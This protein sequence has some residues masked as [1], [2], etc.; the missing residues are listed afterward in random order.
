MAH[1]TNLVMKIVSIQ[2]LVVKLESLLQTT[3]TFVF[4]KKT[5][6]TW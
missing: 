1:H 6:W 3:Y 4:T 2:P 5:F